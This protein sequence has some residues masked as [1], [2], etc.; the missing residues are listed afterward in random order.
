MS[1]TSKTATEGPWKQ[2]SVPP[3]FVYP[4]DFDT[5]VRG[6]SQPVKKLKKFIDR[7]VIASLSDQNDFRQ[8]KDA[9][10]DCL[11]NAPN[12]EFSP[13]SGDRLLETDCCVQTSRRIK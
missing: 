11:M 2:C 1:S 13:A 12:E 7:L 5:N 6:K 3:K 9:N 10:V 8:P 4:T